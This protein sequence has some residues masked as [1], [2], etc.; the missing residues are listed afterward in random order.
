MRPNIL[1]ITTD[2]QRTDTLGAYGS[3]WMDTPH[4]DQLAREGTRFTRAYCTNPVCTPSRASLFSG[5]MP[6]RHGAWNVGCN[7]AEDIPLVSHLL[8]TAG[9]HTHHIGKAHWQAYLAPA[10]HSVEALRENPRFPSYRGPYYG[11]AQVEL[12]IGH[13][14]YNLMAG[15]HAEWVRRQGS[16]EELRRWSQM[17]KHGPA[18]GGNAYDWA[19]P[20]ALHNSTWS[21]DRAVAALRQ[22][23]GADRP[24]LLHVGFQ[25]PHH[26]HAVP[27]D[28]PR[29]VRPE[30]VPAAQWDEQ[31]LRDKP[32]HFRAARAGRLEQEPTRGQYPFAGQDRGYDYTAVT[33]TDAQLGRAYYYTL[34]QLI[35]D[36]VGR[37]LAELAR[38]NLTEETIVI[39]TSDHGELLGDHGLWMKGPFHYEQVVRVPLIAR[40]PG[41]W[42]RGRVEQ[43][44]ISLV[45]LLPTLLT[46]TGVASPAGLDGVSWAGRLADP[47]IPA[48][49]DQVTVE[50]IDDPTGLRLRT[51]I[52]EE[53]KVTFYQDQPY[54]ECYHLATDPE[55]RRNLW[56][57]P[58][59]LGVR[60][61]MLRRWMGEGERRERR[62][63]RLCYA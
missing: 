63:R 46:G 43:A 7:L 24:F 51:F 10:E 47:A 60:E 38:L 12:A 33:A 62:D 2:Q 3:A 50:C 57:D 35:D 34:S 31:E 55:E 13:P 9:Y 36:Q 29:R 18:F 52:D 58:A 56:H 45:D 11:F 54:G 20:V 15:H 42:L 6:S 30:S 17:E 5:L 23:S 61:R 28:Y 26:P 1:L 8:A 49:R 41:R 25:D 48:P 59:T 14:G 27:T 19:L 44:P 16:E 21:A 4:L 53:W 40:W 37:I 39:F 22:Q 32:P